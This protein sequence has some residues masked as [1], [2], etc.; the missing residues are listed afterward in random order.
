MKKF[1]WL[2]VLAGVMFTSV[3]INSCNQEDEVADPNG[4]PANV[5]CDGAGSI[6]YFP[7]ADSNVWVYSGTFG[8]T[9]T[10]TDVETV[11]TGTQYTVNADQGFNDYDEVFIVGSNGDVFLESAGTTVQD[12]N[13]LHVPINP[14]LNQEWIYTIS[15]DGN[16]IR[17]VTSISATVTTSSCTYNDCLEITEFDGTGDQLGTYWF[18]QGVGEV[19]KQVLTTSNLTSVTLN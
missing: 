15:F 10:V 9:K 2:Y 19:S 4:N 12:T 5:L 14:T 3:L 16:K 11:S 6:S 8:A 1:S 18:K 7:L 13:Y 17:R